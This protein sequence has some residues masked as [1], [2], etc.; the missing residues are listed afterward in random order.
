M[1]ALR[2]RA[3]GA[4]RRSRARSRR[5]SS[6][7]RRCSTRPAAAGKPPADREAERRAVLVE[8]V[9]LLEAEPRVRVVRDRRAA[10]ARMRRPVR[11]H[12]LA[13]HERAVRPR[14]VG[15]DRDRL[16]HAVRVASRRP[17]GSSCR[18]SPTAGAPRA[19]GS[20]RTRRPSSCRA[21]SGRARSRRARCTR[22]CTWAS[23]SL[24]LVSFDQRKSPRTPRVLRLRCLAP[25]LCR[26]PRA[27]LI[28]APAGTPSSARSLR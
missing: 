11:E 16:Q 19:S 28:A 6:S 18:R 13:H 24:L 3:R 10:V 7:R 2:G 20:C 17:G 21:G 5:R 26:R 4:R 27:S 25:T 14:R 23:C 8:E 9:L 1:P 22:A 15:E 12:H